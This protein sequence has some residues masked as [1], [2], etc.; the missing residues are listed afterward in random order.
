MSH[1][2]IKMTSRDAI[3]ESL[4]VSQY[5]NE[6]LS[7]EQKRDF[8]LR[9]KDDTKL[10]KALAEELNFKSSLDDARQDYTISDNA[11]SAFSEQLADEPIVKRKG[12][13]NYFQLFGAVAAGVLVSVTVFLAMPMFDTQPEYKTLT[14]THDKPFSHTSQAVYRVILN[15]SLPQDEYEKKIEELGFTII[16]GPEVANSY[17]VESNEVLDTKKIKEVQS[18]PLIAFFEPVNQ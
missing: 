10:Q 9:L 2:V 18:N 6:Q 11:F 4:L 14:N 1:Q 3:D 5:V 15:S 8:E 16:Q 7:P 13:K 12:A 17:L